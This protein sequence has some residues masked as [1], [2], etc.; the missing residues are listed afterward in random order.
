M[1]K[2]IILCPEPVNGMCK[3]AHRMVSQQNS[4]PAHV[5]VSLVAYCTWPIRLERLNQLWQNYP[6]TPYKQHMPGSKEQ[7]L[8]RC[9]SPAG[10]KLVQCER[11]EGACSK[12]PSTFRNLKTSRGSGRQSACM[13]NTQVRVGC[14]FEQC[15]CLAFW[16]CGDLHTESKPADI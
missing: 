5:H 2:I 9:C 10:G 3:P 7:S 15:I 16:F 12:L 14:D 8:G 1:L 6:S 11:Y 13:L 4:Q